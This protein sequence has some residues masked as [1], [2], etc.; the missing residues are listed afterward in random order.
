MVPFNNSYRGG[1][2][3]HFYHFKLFDLIW[4]LVILISGCA[5]DAKR[6][7]SGCA[8]DVKRYFSGCAL[9][10]K[11]GLRPTTLN[12]TF[13]AAPGKIATLGNSKINFAIA[14]AKRYL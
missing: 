14:L 13:R 2:L 4:N 9:D 3:T 11:F 10:V 1:M 6:Y 8:L 7:F 5:L 12:A